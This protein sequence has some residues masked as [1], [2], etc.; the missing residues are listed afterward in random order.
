M[1]FLS[2]ALILG[3]DVL[4]A[5]AASSAKAVPVPI[6]SEISIAATTD[7]FII[8]F[9]SSFS[10]AKAGHER[11]YI[12]LCSSRLRLFTRSRQP[13]KTMTDDTKKTKADT[14]PKETAPKTDAAAKDKSPAAKD[15][16]KDTCQAGHAKRRHQSPRA[17]RRPPRRR[18]TT[19][20][21]KARNRSPRPTR[22][23]GTRFSRRRKRRRKS[24]SEAY[25]A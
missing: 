19:A 12:S 16:P 9:S 3:A 7:D 10:A 23:T 6:A 24:D 14:A 1:A 17:A 20:G 13:G 2:A 21:A 22:K 5:G 25:V 18:P 15:T 4:A 11:T 8:G